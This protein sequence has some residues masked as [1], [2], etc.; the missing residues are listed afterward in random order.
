MVDSGLALKDETKPS[1]PLEIYCVLLSV[2]DS[3]ISTFSSWKR[4]WN[5]LNETGCLGPTARE[6]ESQEK[7]NGI[8]KVDIVREISLQL[9]NLTLVCP[10]LMYWST[11]FYGTEATYLDFANTDQEVYGEE[12]STIWCLHYKG[13]RT[14]M[15]DSRKLAFDLSPFFRQQFSCSFFSV[16]ELL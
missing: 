10:W 11:V 13:S 3:N 2:S 15:Q 12:K 1:Y 14:W 9:C 8:L 7:K 5:A 6:R 16:G 4:W